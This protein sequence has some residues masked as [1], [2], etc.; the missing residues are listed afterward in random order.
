MT[1]SS[2][3]AAQAARS[4]LSPFAFDRREPQPHDVVIDIAYCGVC[5]S[6]VHYVDNDMG[7]STFPVVPGHEI[8]G[9]VTS[10]GPAVTKFKM[11]DLAAI[12]CYVDSC[13]VCDSCRTDRQQMCLEG[14]VGSFGGFERDRKQRTWG[15]FSNNYVAN[16]D[17]VFHMPTNLNLAAAAPLLC[18]GITTYSPLR[19]WQTGKGSKVGIVGLGGLGHLAVKLAAAMGAEVVVFTNSPGKLGDA[20]KL[21]AA[22]ALVATDA[23]RMKSQ[24]GRL[25]FILDTVSAA[26]NIDAYI[27]CLKPGGTLCLLGIDP[28]PLSFSPLQLVFGQKAVVGSLIGGLE[29]TQAM[30][31][32]CGA[33]GI[34]A[35]IELHPAGQINEAFARLR[36]NDVKYRFVLDMST[37]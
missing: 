36:R 14:M 9:R 29:E 8:V 24:Q 11:G 5:H 6:D 33:H 25:D 31:D 19:K 18:A 32:F 16:E 10:I 21:G 20:K 27:A 3:Y 22:D 23:D 30:L 35:D 12:G 13:R 4:P 1:R 17:Y 37:L 2:G 7:F 15:G 28:K 26:H 34:T